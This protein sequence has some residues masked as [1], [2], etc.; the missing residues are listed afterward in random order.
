MSKLINAPIAIFSY[1]REDK[2]SNLISSLLE[3]DGFY[4]SKIF[5]FCDGSKNEEDLEKVEKTRKTIRERLNGNNNVCYIE[6]KE[7]I[8]LAKSIYNGINYV[9]DLFDRVIVL[10]DDLQVNKGFLNYMN[11]ALSKYQNE[12]KVFQISGHFFEPPDLNI[13]KAIFLPFISTWG[14]A[15][16]K[17]KW[18]GFNLEKKISLTTWNNETIREFNLNNSYNYYY[19]LKG[20]FKNK[21]QSWGVLWYLH[22]FQNQGLV[23]YPNSSLIVN[24][25]FDKEATNTTKS[26]SFQKETKDLVE[27]NLPSEVKFNSDTFETVSKY[28]KSINKDNLITWV[29][30]KINFYR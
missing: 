28:I 1:N 24:R 16:W 23:L 17:S 27:I 14:W 13:N 4:N 22:V 2:I 25:G 12:N 6:Q 7:N 11:L 21:I 8:G 26:N 3:C 15:T 10:E 30:K 18:K 9:F 29:L 19:I 5:F 20:V